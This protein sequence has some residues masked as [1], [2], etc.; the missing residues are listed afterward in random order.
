MP[1]EEKERGGEYWTLVLNYQTAGDWAGGAEG[2]GLCGMQLR[3]E[4][5][6][7]EGLRG[8]QAQ[9]MVGAEGRGLQRTKPRGLGESLR[10]WVQ[11]REFGDTTTVDRMNSK[12]LRGTM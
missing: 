5:V 2:T 4:R 7:V 1:R 9:R 12:G 6:Q 11:A 8:R 3:G 10:G